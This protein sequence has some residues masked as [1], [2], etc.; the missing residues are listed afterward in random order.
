[1]HAYL[2]APR[3]VQ[4]GHMLAG[5]LV[6]F[7]TYAY[8][9]E[10]P[11][12]LGFTFDPR[13][14]QITYLN[15]AGE[16]RV[17]DRIVQVGAVTFVAFQ[18]N[19][20]QRLLADIQP[21]DLV[22]LVVER[23]DQTLVLRW[24]VVRIEPDD[25]LDWMRSQWFLA[26][27]FWGFGT[28]TALLVR[29]QNERWRLLIAFL[30]LTALNL[31][32]SAAARDHVAESAII[33]R[34]V[35]WASVPVFW[36]LH[37]VFPQPFRRQPAWFRASVYLITA[38]LIGLEWF[39]RLPPS[40]YL[41]AFLIALLG[42]I[43]P[44]SWRLFRPGQGRGARL[45]WGMGLLAMAPTL[46]VGIA[47]LLI[48]NWPESYT[49]LGIYFGWP[50]LPA[51]YFYA[52]YRRQ[53]GG[54]EMRANRALG[55]YL[56]TALLTAVLAIGLTL[57]DNWR[58]FRDAPVVA[59]ILAS[60]G[61][62]LGTLA[63]YP[64]FQRW[65]EA[66]L[67]GIPFRANQL[68]GH[69]AARLTAVADYA[70]LE[71]VLRG[72]LLPSLQVRQSQLLSLSSA[73][74]AETVYAEDVAPPAG[75][76]EVT[77]LLAEADRYRPPAEVQSQPMLCPWVRLA[78]PLRLNNQLVGVWLLGR[79]DPD[80]FYA[81]SELSAFR[82]LADQTAIALAHIQQ[83]RWMR[84]LFQANINRDEQ[85]R[86]QL[87]LELHDEI[88]NELALLTRAGSQPEAQVPVQRI[89]ARVRQ[90]IAGLRPMMLEYGLSTAV[91]QLVDDLAERAGAEPQMLL[92]IQ[93]T[94]RY[95]TEVE[96][97]LFRIVQQAGENA[98]KHA[99]AR[100]VR[101]T[102]K[103]TDEEAYLCVEDD[104]VGLPPD[105]QDDLPALIAQRHFGLAGM[106]ERAVA[107]NAELQ[108][109]A[110]PG[111]GT[112]LQ[113]TWRRPAASPQLAAEGR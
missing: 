75:P 47:T 6:L 38:G 12:Y 22:P 26:W 41:G 50:V 21:G 90:M 83:T 104:G 20:R 105:V 61:A 5:L 92:D 84:E 89:V 59:A 46:A 24:P 72:E 8:F 78:L 107:V 11:Y 106:H 13:T 2:R 80:D 82:S 70:S 93:G 1:M 96:Q 23:D 71:R 103:L 88:L 65:L 16:L 19:Q 87:A 86:A 25:T 49:F 52:A 14:G 18:Q 35:N 91:E 95:P 102:G 45:L 40:L 31:I 9:A 94:A 69:F 74:A 48:P 63:V 42:I 30:D 51:V 37:W 109:Y 17:G 10:I 108:L 99:R 58:P 3:V 27:V 29:P 7:Y 67:L 66:D 60:A 32:T 54:L 73:E 28:L 55:L 33:G 68:A 53:L 64:R 112:R 97:H 79:R 111:E 113:V 81:Q 39:Q 100:H 15:R 36:H 43:L 101:I 44:L 56:F 85:A 110:M 98:L 62:G 34:M 77:R 76:A 57:I 4:A